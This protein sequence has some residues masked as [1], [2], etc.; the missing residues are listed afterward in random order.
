M[1]RQ[2]AQRIENLERAVACY[3]EILND[4]PIAVFEQP[5]FAFYRVGQTRLF[6]DP[7]APSAL[8]YF[9]VPDV[10]VRIEELRAA[11]FTVSSEPHVVFPDPTGIF[12]AAGNEWLAFVTDSEGNQVGL[13]SREKTNG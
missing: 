9:E 12:D 2:V 5:G 11:G 4:Q 3:N 6:L 1:I 7:N 8:I 10:R 13:M